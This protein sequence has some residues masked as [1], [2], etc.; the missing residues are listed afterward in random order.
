MKNV[1]QKLSAVF[2]LALL[3]SLN[4]CFVNFDSKEKME[5]NG[6]VVEMSVDQDDFEGLSVN[7]VF[8]VL[9][10]PGESHSVTITADENLMEHIKIEIKDD[11]LHIT[12]EKDFKTKEAIKVDV[13]AEEIN[14]VRI[15]GAA[16]CESTGTLESDEIEMNIAG[17][18]NIKLGL[19]TED[20]KVNIS[21]A[22]NLEL[23]GNADE[24]RFGISGAGNLQAYDLKTHKTTLKMSGAGNA[25]VYADEDLN[26]SLSGIGRVSYKG[27]PEN[28]QKN[29]SGLGVVSE[30]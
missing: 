12:S 14:Y 3:F 9:L 26:V 6:D 24:S 19:D 5:G 10:H 20:L 11:V 16:N 25:E 17:A 29:V 4:G 7:G 1:T 21:G 2:M 28:L 18:G 13:Y 27:S 8:D 23:K 22:G 30:G 15:G